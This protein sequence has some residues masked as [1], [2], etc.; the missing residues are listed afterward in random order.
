M[1]VAEP[2]ATPAPPAASTDPVIALAAAL[3]HRGLHVLQ[4][5]GPTIKVVL[6]E[7]SQ[8]VTLHPDDDIPW[9][10]LTWPGT[11]RDDEP[12]CPAEWTTDAADIIV[13]IVAVPA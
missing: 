10:W 5:D 13:R 7:R 9:W 4:D 3:R 11:G 2:L 8:S 6:D 1:A 12:L